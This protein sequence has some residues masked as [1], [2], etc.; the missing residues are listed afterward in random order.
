MPSRALV[1]GGGGPVGIGWESG[2]IAGLGECGVR[3]AE[4]GY[5]LGTSAGAFVGAQLAL[6]RD[7]AEMYQAQLSAAGRYEGSDRASG[8]PPNMMGLMGIMQA[9]ARGEMSV[10]E[11]R[12]EAGRLSLNSQ[13]MGE[14]QFVSTMSAMQNLPDEWPSQ[15]YACTAIDA[16]TGELVT[17]ANDSGVRLDHAVTSSCAV[18]GVYPAIT[19][20][21]RRYYDG[22]IGTATNSTLARGHERVLVVAVGGG[23]PPVMTD[24]I[25]MMRERQMERFEAEVQ[26]L[27]DAGSQVEVV[28]PDPEAIE[29]FG[30]NVMDATR[31]R[32]AAEAGLAQGRREADRLRS[33]WA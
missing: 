1:L 3:L 24:E 15:P 25:R 17:W 22:G 33:F 13:T 27:R 30:M 16:L 21:G 18:P 9:L 5:I 20:N 26:E 28:R 10:P 8:P 31:R 6:G 4:A 7:P 19:I 12:K 2:L 14:E 32:P 11:L 23:T 29:A